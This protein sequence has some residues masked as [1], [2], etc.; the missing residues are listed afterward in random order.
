MIRYATMKDKEQGLE[1]LLK[2]V[3]DFDF[4]KKFEIDLTEYYDKLLENLI[5]DKTIIVSEE[6]GIINGCLI[7]A[8]VPNALNPYLVQLQILAA[9]VR[10]DK[11]GS[12]IFYRMNNFLDKEFK[13]FD[14]IYS[15]MP[16][17]T[18]VKFDK[19]GYKKIS[20]N[21]IKER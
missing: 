19:L 8:R 1:L 16:N 2:H 7:G 6:D 14:K 5:I 21:Y 3:K 17:V 18:N 15:A 13:N 10:E 12:S 9:W 20:I 4:A 11:R